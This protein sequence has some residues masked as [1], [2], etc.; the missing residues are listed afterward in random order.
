MTETKVVLKLA[1]KLIYLKLSV[2]TKNSMFFKRN[3]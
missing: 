2:L 1:F 3:T